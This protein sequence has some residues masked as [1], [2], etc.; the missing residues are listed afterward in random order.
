MWHLSRGIGSAAA[1]VSRLICK[2]SNPLYFLLIEHGF[3]YH[4]NWP[5]TRLTDYPHDVDAVSMSVCS[6]TWSA[7]RH[8]LKTCEHTLGLI[9]HFVFN[10]TSLKPKFMK[11]TCNDVGTHKFTDFNSVPAEAILRF[12]GSF[13]LIDE[14]YTRDSNCIYTSKE[15]AEFEV[16]MIRLWISN[17]NSIFAC[18]SSGVV[19][20]LGDMERNRRWHSFLSYSNVMSAEKS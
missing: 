19:I 13:I 7:S 16:T 20:V 3:Y 14:I 15:R 11:W 5:Q 8:E 2:M 18:V 17:F 4:Y 10:F 9:L 1:A 12:F 6:C